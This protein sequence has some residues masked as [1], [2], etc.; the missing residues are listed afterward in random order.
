MRTLGGHQRELI[1]RHRPDRPV[2]QHERH[3]VH[4]TLL[5]LAHDSAEG[6]TGIAVGEQMRMLIR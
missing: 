5:D 2:R 3:T 1:E 6:L 4:V